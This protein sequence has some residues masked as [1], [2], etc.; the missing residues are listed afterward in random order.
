MGLAIFVDVKGLSNLFF[1]KVSTLHVQNKLSYTVRN[2]LIAFLVLDV[3]TV[4][5]RP[6]VS[7]TASTDSQQSP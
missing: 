2:S 7:L 5:Y 6:C 4:L 1:S 3:M